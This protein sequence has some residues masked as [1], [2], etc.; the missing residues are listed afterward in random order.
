MKGITMEQLERFR[1]RESGSKEIRTLHAAL[2]KT[3]IKELAF[4]PS[5]AAKLNGDFSVELKTRGITWQQK[6]GRC[7]LYAAMNILRERVAEKC[8][9][10]RFE[11]SGNYLSFYDKLEKANNMLE[12]VIDN[13]DK[14][15][16][17]RMMEYILDGVHDG[18]YWTMA[19][20]L[21]RKY[22]VVPADVMPETWQSTHTEKFMKLYNAL[23][24]K[25]AA[26]LRMLAAE[27]ADLEE[28]K[29][30]MLEEFYRMECIAFGEPPASF[31]FEY[32]DKDNVFH[33]EHGLTGKT[34]Y[35]KYAD[36][37]L[38][39]YVTVTN[40]PTH[41]LPMNL[42]YMFHYKGSMADSDVIC[43]NLTMDELETLVIRQLEDGEPVWFG[44][45]SGAYG[46]RD[47]GVWDPDS[48]DFEGLMGGIDFFMKKG[49]RLEYH[50]SYATHAMIFVG[51]NFD[52]TGIPNRWKIE[53][54]W[55]EE[56]GKK[57]YFVCS[58][59]YFREYVYEAVINRK[60]LTDS[61]K[62]LLE[63]DPVRINPWESDSL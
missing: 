61:Q 40:H 62:A 9:L 13:I 58:E 50:D 5:E 14:P 20:D 43:L 32:R 4:V 23:L 1:N 30:K 37:V 36:T 28:A 52:E 6:S 48:L 38:D 16:N 51:V 8:G 57:G 47:K 29:E 19:S 46:D 31:S 56:A 49:D 63:Q 17:D 25:D 45:D 11:L 34:F 59:K 60:H 12:M 21:V 44:C 54:S 55:G 39:D 15:L 53:N 24:H 27:G 41:G 7:W 10:E 18:G 42:R 35:E 2:A 26:K 22:G 3:E 33:A